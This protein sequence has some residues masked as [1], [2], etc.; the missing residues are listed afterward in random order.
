MPLG[1][2]RRG[3]GEPGLESG[4]IFIRRRV[5]IEIFGAGLEVEILEGLKSLGAATLEDSKL[6]TVVLLD[7]GHDVFVGGTRGKGGAD[8]EE[9]V[10]SL[11]SLGNR[12]VLV[13]SGVVLLHTDEEDEDRD[14]G[15]DCVR[16]TSECHVGTSNVVVSGNMASSDPGKEGGIAKVDVLHG[17]QSQ[18]RVTQ[19]HVNVQQAD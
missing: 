16:P 17:L 11:T 13:R 2:I 6:V 8:G 1:R 14:E 3:I 18:S 4:S 10:H 7:N 19:Q 15:F 9:G 5:N 12:A